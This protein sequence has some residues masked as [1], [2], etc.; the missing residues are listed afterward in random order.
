MNR[1][2]PFFT[3]I[4]RSATLAMGPRSGLTQYQQAAQEECRRQAVGSKI[5]P[6][7][8]IWLPWYEGESRAMSATGT[9]T[10]TLD[11]GGQAIGT[12]VHEIGACFR[13]ALVLEGL[14][15]RVFGGLT[16][17]VN[18][19]RSKPGL[20]ASWLSENAAATGASEMFQ[21]LQLS[22]H[23]VTAYLDV[24]L[25]LL[26]E[27]EAAEKYLRE[28]LIRALAVEIQRQVIGGSGAQNVPLGII[29]VAGI[30]TE[31]GSVSGA[32]PTFQNL[33][34]LEYQVTGV[35]KAD[36]GN[37]GWLTSPLARKKLRTTPIF[38]N[39]SVPIWRKPYQLLGYP[40]AVT[41]SV[42]DTLTKGAS[43]NVCSAIIFG[44]W[45]EL[46]MGFWGPGIEVDAVSSVAAAQAGQV[47][48]IAAAH[49]DS[50]MRLA[51]GFAAMTDA[52]CA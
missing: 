50:G 42:P 35:N 41:P 2:F 52:L 49:F 33:C 9:T 6:Q 11:Q 30:V 40:A 21:S 45:S 16:A 26:A 32:A 29:N 34:N 24:S 37:L 44:E 47:T 15:A 3:E 22:P 13:D 43:G 7:N 23:R 28:E 5:N 31:V 51:E 27:Q 46:F 10:A 25:E 38:A 39:G 1:R 48:M 19:P 14:G 36:R 17:N 20:A 8:G 4:A 12:E 18:F